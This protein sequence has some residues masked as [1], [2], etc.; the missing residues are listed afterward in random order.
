MSDDQSMNTV[1]HNIALEQ[2]LVKYEADIRRHISIE[3]Q[4]QLFAD[5]LKRSISTLEK[6]KELLE[7]QTSHELEEL[8]KDK[9]T[10]REFLNTKEKNIKDLK[11]QLKLA[12]NDYAEI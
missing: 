10:M 8:K 7:S 6:E 5:D 12:Q 1:Q 11:E 4:L 2:Q 3:H 9:L